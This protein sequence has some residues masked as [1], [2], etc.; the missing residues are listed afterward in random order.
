MGRRRVARISGQEISMMNTLARLHDTL[1]DVMHAFPVE[2]TTL[3]NKTPRAMFIACYT[4]AFLDTPIVGLPRDVR[5]PASRVRSR[6]RRHLLPLLSYFAGSIVPSRPAADDVVA[7][8]EWRRTLKLLA[9]RAEMGA[10]QW[11]TERTGHPKR[12]AGA[13]I[14]WLEEN[15]ARPW[16][17]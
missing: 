16:L 12:T 14:A 2:L 6:V 7:M 1:A 15:D 10:V 17:A 4:T 11:I 3:K 8:V 5:R 13:I 9:I